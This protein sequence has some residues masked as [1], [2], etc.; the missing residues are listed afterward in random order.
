MYED[1]DWEEMEPL[2]ALKANKRAVEHQAK[3]RPKNSG[4]ISV[5]FLSAP[6]CNAGG[7]FTDVQ[8]DANVFF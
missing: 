1:A 7:N 5:A 8:P 6:I 4:E 3:Q 2:E